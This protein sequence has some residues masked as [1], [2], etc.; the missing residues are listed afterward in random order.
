MKSDKLLDVTYKLII[1]LRIQYLKK[2]LVGFDRL[3]GE[4]TAR[5]LMKLL[6][7]VTSRYFFESLEVC[8]SLGKAV[9]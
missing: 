5:N 4:Y 9:I 2:L 6:V 3:L 1:L 7:K 8:P